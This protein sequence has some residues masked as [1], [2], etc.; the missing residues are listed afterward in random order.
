MR[1]ELRSYA[2]AMA[3]LTTEPPLHHPRFRLSL[4]TELFLKKII[5]F[6]E[7]K[8]KF[9]GGKVYAYDH[10]IHV[11]FFKHYRFIIPILSYY[12]HSFFEAE[13]DKYLII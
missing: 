4:T 3:L 13:H 9:S 5:S 10:I 11:L 8:T 7:Q 6:I 12:F 2:G 1:K